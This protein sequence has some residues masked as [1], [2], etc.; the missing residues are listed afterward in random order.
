MNCITPQK[1]ERFCAWAVPASVGVGRLSTLSEFENEATNNEVDDW[2]WGTSAD[3]TCDQAWLSDSSNVACASSIMVP[4][5]LPVCQRPLG[6]NGNHFCDLIGNVAELVKNNSG[7]YEAYGHAYDSERNNLTPNYSI[8][9]GTPSNTP[10]IGFR[11]YKEG[12]TWQ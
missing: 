8:L 6:N 11:C 5:T 9:L 7:Q 3:P 10:Q 2:P 4:A 1:A 12:P